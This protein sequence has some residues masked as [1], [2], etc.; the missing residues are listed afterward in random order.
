MN[1]SLLPKIHKTTALARLKNGDNGNVSLKNMGGLNVKILVSEVEEYEKRVKMAGIISDYLEN[2]R[3][4]Q[5]GSILAFS[6]QKNRLEQKAIKV[7]GIS[8]SKFLGNGHTS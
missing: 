3:T 1:S 5:K 8:H 2:F 7:E 4:K 6:A